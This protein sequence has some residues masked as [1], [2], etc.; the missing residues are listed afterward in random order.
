MIVMTTSNST[1]VKPFVCDVRFIFLTR[2]VVK[3][4]RRVS[5]SVAFRSRFLQL[6]D[7][8][9]AE[10]GGENGDLVDRSEQR[11]RIVRRLSGFQ[12]PMVASPIFSFGPS[13]QFPFLQQSAIDVARHAS[14][15]RIV[16]GGPRVPASQLGRLAAVELER[17][18]A[19]R[20]GKRELDRSQR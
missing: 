2:T 18:L 1:N 7:F 17:A 20:R 8:C 19:I 16:D 5:T 10:R 3:R 13:G 15:R 11:S 14:G 4:K 9:V 12:L 6:L